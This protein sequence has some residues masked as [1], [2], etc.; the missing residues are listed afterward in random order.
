VGA[1]TIAAGIPAPSE[2]RGFDPAAVEVLLCD[3]D[4]NLFPSEEPAFVAS[5][6]VTNRCLAI[7][8]V[9]RRYDA[10]E[11][12]LAATGRNF[13][14]TIADLAREAGVGA[15]ITADALERWVAEE[16]RAVSAHLA[17]TLKPDPAVLEPLTRL[18]GRFGLAAVSS[19]ALGRLAACFE[20]T[21]LDELFPSERRFS[22][23]DSLPAPASKPDPAIYTFAARALG[24]AGPQGLAIEDS[25]PGVLSAVAAG[26]ATVGNV[27]FVAPAER[28]E[29]VDALLAAGAGGVVASW[30][31]LEALLT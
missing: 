7:L 17:Q 23:E 31:E 11:L 9:A 4:G 14:S 22:A 24:V 21:A 29:R 5:A 25:V 27:A 8:G 12:R 20:A 2:P 1:V 18:R 6:E 10:Q 13:R 19:S 30:A 16:K 3:A 15:A 26:F 28:R